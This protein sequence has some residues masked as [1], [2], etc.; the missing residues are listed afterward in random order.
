MNEITKKNNINSFT[1]IEL[2]L[3]IS[4]IAVLSGMLLPA[5][6]GAR[7]K[8]RGISCVSN[9]KQL[10]MASALYLSDYG[11]YVPYQEAHMKMAEDGM[12][13]VGYRDDKKIDLKRGGFLKTY[14]G[15]NAE[16]LICPE[17]RKRIADISS[18]EGGTGYGYNLYGVGSHAYFGKKYGCGA[19]VKAVMVRNPTATVAFAD[20]AR[21]TSHGTLLDSPKGIVMVYSPYTVPSECEDYHKIVFSKKPDGTTHFRHLRSANVMWCDGHV[22][23]EKPSR[24]NADDLARRELVGFFG[25]DDNSLFDPWNIVE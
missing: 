24:L 6:N 25:P 12:M 15:D 13:W 22:S 9:L 21:S 7:I 4:V 10:G 16:I 19:G 14:C 11:Y 8:A 20:T 23:T 18:I 17:W 1:L 2:L 3:V 5:L